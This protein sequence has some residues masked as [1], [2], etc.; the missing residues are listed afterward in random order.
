MHSKCTLPYCPDDDDDDGFALPPGT[1]VHT[2]V[3]RFYVETDAGQ[4]DAFE[5]ATK[6]VEAWDEFLAAHRL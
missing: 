6:C 5:L 4:M 1:P 3:V 2:V